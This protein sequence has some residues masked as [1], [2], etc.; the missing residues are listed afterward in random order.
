LINEAAEAR[1]IED[2]LL[3][4]TQPAQQLQYDGWLLRLARND[5]KRAS[6]VNATYGSS[7]PLDQKIQHC[8]R[9]YAEAGLPPLFRVTPFSK[10]ARLDEA[11]AGR[12]YEQFERSLCMS[13]SLEEAPPVSRADLR[14]ER[15]H[16]SR[17]LD[18]AAEL[19]GLSEECRQAEYERLFES[20]LPGFSLIAWL[21][22]E[23]VG[24]GLT[25][26]E[27]EYAGLFDV[28]TSEAHRGRGIGTALCVELM[29]T[30]RLHGAGHAWLSV[31][32]DNAPA[33]RV[34]EKL[35][36]RPVYDY[37]YRRRPAWALD[38]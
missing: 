33:L 15:P 16:L 18:I 25:M 6:S 21:G 20:T 5:V 19:R 12:G 36:F 24:C 22:E 1:R 37:W 13:A 27:D 35:G 7:L 28:C 29:R 2:L 31:L 38:L 34:Y 8:E 11:L 10:P 26:V 17:W 4:A 23:A 9:V 30:A 3:N 14:F 32:D